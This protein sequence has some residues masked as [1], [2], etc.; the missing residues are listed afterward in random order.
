M[1]RRRVRILIGVAFLLA[2]VLSTGSAKAWEYDCRDNDPNP[3]NSYEPQPRS[4]IF[5]FVPQAYFTRNSSGKQVLVRC[6]YMPSPH[7][8]PKPG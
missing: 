8:A 4:G 5:R 1:V 6:I 2:A 7:A 3:S